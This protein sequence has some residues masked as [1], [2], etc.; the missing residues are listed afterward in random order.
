MTGVVIVVLLLAEL[1]SLVVEETEEFAVIEATVTLGARS[2]SYTHL[3]VYK[4][5]G[6]GSQGDRC[7]GERRGRRGATSFQ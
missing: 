1:G 4:R 6:R 5:Q 2:V 7:R 3:D